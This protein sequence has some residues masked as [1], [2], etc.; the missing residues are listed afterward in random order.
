VICPGG[1]PREGVVS[2]GGAVNV[3]S[4]GSRPVSSNKD[5]KLRINELIDDCEIYEELESVRTS[6]VVD[7]VNEDSLVSI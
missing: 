7:S 5:L 2:K 6:E 4:T 1:C 3:S